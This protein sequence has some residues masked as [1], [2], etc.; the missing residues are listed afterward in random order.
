MGLA[1]E[2]ARG[3]SPAGAVLAASPLGTPLTRALF[4]GCVEKPIPERQDLAPSASPSGHVKSFRLFQA[5]ALCLLRKKIGPRL[6]IR[7][8]YLPKY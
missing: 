3:G 4:D 2:G 6:L 7:P 5:N 1:K 8:N